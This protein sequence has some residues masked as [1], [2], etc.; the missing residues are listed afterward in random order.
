MLNQQFSTFL[1]RALAS[2]GR[3]LRALGARPVDTP[4]TIPLRLM[5]LVF[6]MLPLPSRA[7]VV[8][9]H[10]VSSTLAAN[11]VASIAVAVPAGTRI[12][13]LM[14][15]AVSAHGTNGNALTIGTPAGW[16]AIPAASDGNLNSGTILR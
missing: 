13:D 7:L 4:L 3:H 11:Q 8:G 12:G 6:L 16:T 14:L 5:L 15:A 1:A 2:A 9:F 10:E